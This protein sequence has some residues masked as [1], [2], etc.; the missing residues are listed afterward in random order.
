MDMECT[1]ASR[2]PEKLSE[3]S[4]AVSIITG[5]EIE[6]AGA[7][8]IPDALRLGTALDVAQLDGH[9]WA[10]SARGFNTTVANK[11]QVLLDGRS[12]YTPLFSGVF[13]DVQQTFLPDIAQIEVIRGPGATLWGANAINGVINILTKSADQTQGFLLYGGGGLENDGFGGLR[14]GGKA[15]QDTY[16]R[17]YV[18]GQ[19]NDG[20]P[21]EGDGNEDGSH[22][23]QGGF[24]I[25]SKI[26]PD[27]TITLQGDFYGGTEDQ[28]PMPGDIGVDG[29]NA[30]GRWTRQFDK[31][32]SGMLQVYYDRTHRLIPNVFEEERNTFDIELQHQ[33]RYDEHYIVWGGNYRVSHD[34]I[35]NLGPGLAF[36]PDEDTQH[37]VSGYIQ[38]EWHI[39]PDAFYLT[40]GTKFEYNTFSGFEIQPTG[41]FTW[42]PAP[43]Q[44][45]WG[46]ISRAVRTPA[47][48]DQ[49]LA[50]P[51]PAFAPP[52]L[53]PN[54]D[55]DS[56]TLV[57]Y[58]LGYRIKATSDLS[59][60]VVAYYND[61]ENLRS[62]E[63]LSGGRF[64]IG[65]KLEGESYGGTIAAKWRIADWWRVDGSVTLFD[66]DIHKAA[67]GHDVNNGAGEAN[68]PEV[69]F[70]IHSA[71]DLPHNLRFDSFLRY[72]DD[73]PNPHTP[74][75][76][77]GDVRL[78]WSPRK[79][80]EIAIVGRNLFDDT[81]PEFRRTTNTREVERSVFVT[82][83]W[84]Y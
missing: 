15:G 3:T 82:F 9:T 48:L 23:I 47:R 73:R 84:S 22:M 7:T 70:I 63:P 60:D 5:E 28:Q 61:Y 14:Y 37:L 4:S 20:L 1:S 6:R 31:D 71:M 12:L 40:G 76:L 58:E 26:N 33:F 44:T 24:R 45:L 83:K 13:W 25:D 80:M 8:N 51:N 55:F 49:D 2:R 36:L 69:S 57:A 52:V 75:Y 38:D 79:N 11:M 53:L 35:G 56:E 66:I 27:D 50:S 64:T 78:G 18:M 46:A 54:P 10:I 81:H 29:Q 21:L 39:V 43:N 30:L 34:D 68:D 16:Y 72:V 77:T 42:L 62:V 65:N 74:S 32:S 41:R 19:N 17:V 59:F 67:G